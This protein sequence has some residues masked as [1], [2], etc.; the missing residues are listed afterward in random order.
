MIRK[1]N[2]NK[3]IKNIAL[4]IFEY[5]LIYYP[6]SFKNKILSKSQKKYYL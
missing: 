1:D 5:I 2:N 4:L 3:Y 6:F